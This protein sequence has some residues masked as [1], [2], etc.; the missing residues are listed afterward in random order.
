M[1]SYMN[2]NFT[3]AYLLNQRWSYLELLRDFP[4]EKITR[5]IQRAYLGYFIIGQFR[6]RMVGAFSFKGSTHNSILNVPRVIHP[7]KVFHSI[8]S[9]F[10]VDM[11]HLGEFFGIRNV[12]FRNKSVN[13][14]A[15]DVF[16]ITE[17]NHFVPVMKINWFK[18]FTIMGLSNSFWVT[19]NFSFLSDRVQSFVSRYVFHGFSLKTVP[20]LRVGTA[21]KAQS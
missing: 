4:L 17:F 16:P 3:S 10:P 18:K 15:F 7:F 1:S 5:L 21:L 13:E 19:P 20:A 14:F 11:V 2:P 9:G 8:I 6:E 12:S